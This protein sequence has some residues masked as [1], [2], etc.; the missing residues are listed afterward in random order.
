MT[1][2]VSSPTTA[3]ETGANV[4]AWCG[5]PLSS[6]GIRPRVWCST[7]CRRR[8]DHVDRQLRLREEALVA[9]HGERG[10]TRYSPTEIRRRITVLRAEVLSLQQPSDLVV[11]VA[12]LERAVAELRAALPEKRGSRAVPRFSDDQTFLALV[13]AAVHG[14]AFNVA[15]LLEHARV[16]ADLGRALANLSPLQVG[17]KLRALAGRVLG[18]VELQRVGRDSAGVVWAVHL[19]ADAG[20]LRGDAL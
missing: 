10:R 14:C 8:A 5:R 17:H 6:G 2:I 11:R 3:P 4:C 19:H 13:A 12:A 1:E 9:W 18:G 20:D 16:D 7:S 15:E